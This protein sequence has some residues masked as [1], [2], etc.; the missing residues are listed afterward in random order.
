[1]SVMTCH[2][3]GEYV[4]TDLFPGNWITLGDM[5]K[6]G[7]PDVFICERCMEARD[8]EREAQEA[9]ENAGLNEYLTRTKG[10]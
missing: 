9:A 7:Y 5:R 4:D 6:S 1:M 3:C 10:N 8:A 2:D